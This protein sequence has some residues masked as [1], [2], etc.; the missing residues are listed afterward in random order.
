MNDD[1]RRDDRPL[2]RGCCGRRGSGWRMIAVDPEGCDLARGRTASP[3]CRSPRP[4]VDAAALREILTA[5]AQGRTLATNAPATADSALLIASTRR[6]HPG[7]A[8]LA[9]AKNG[10][11]R[12]PSSLERTSEMLKL[13]PLISQ[14]AR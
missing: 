2:R 3:A 6:R 12:R 9:N 13:G 1:L 8:G 5:L 4:A 14:S 11:C 7:D 10:T